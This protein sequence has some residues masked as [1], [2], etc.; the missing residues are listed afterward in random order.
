MH[1]IFWL[2]ILNGRDHSRDLG[3]DG[4]LILYWILGKQVGKLWTGCIWLRVGAS[5]GPF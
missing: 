2:G 4:K 1:T 5:G 3:V